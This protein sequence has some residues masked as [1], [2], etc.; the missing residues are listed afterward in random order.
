MVLFASCWFVSIM[1]V[2][3]LLSKRCNCKCGFFWFLKTFHFI[4]NSTFFDF[5]DFREKQYFR[6]KNNSHDS[7]KNNMNVMPRNIQKLLWILD[8]MQDA[9]TVVYRIRC[10]RYD[11][12]FS[13]PVILVI[14]VIFYFGHIW[15]FDNIW[16]L[17]WP[18]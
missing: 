9:G 3:L 15:N 1:Y 11:Q 17:I 16:L 14:L 8:E 18:K 10:R 2:L 6:E 5:L 4:K 12:K 13:C 7:I